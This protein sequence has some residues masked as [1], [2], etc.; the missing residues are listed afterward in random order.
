MVERHWLPGFR[1]KTP[2]GEF[3]VLRVADEGYL[4]EYVSGPWEGKHIVMPKTIGA[5]THELESL[6]LTSDQK[7]KLLDVFYGEFPKE[8]ENLFNYF[9][10]TTGKAP[11]TVVMIKVLEE[12]Y[13]PLFQ[14]ALNKFFQK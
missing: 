9:Y 12:E 14:I 4:V 6:R 2:K 11:K 13:P 10:N 1:G 3:V 8:F 5:Q 7:E